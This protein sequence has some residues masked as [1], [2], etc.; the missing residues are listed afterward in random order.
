MH[1]P[2]I[3]H[4]KSGWT[5]DVAARVPIAAFRRRNGSVSRMKRADIDTR[6]PDISGQSANDAFLQHPPTMFARRRHGD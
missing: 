3:G 4:A 5:D 1:C 2:Q 6:F